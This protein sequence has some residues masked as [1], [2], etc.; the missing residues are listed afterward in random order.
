MKTL[1]VDEFKYVHEAFPVA[2]K[3]ELIK[4]KGVYPYDY[5]DSFTRFD[6]SRLPSQDA[7]ISKLSDSLCSDTEYAHATQVW[8]AFECESMAD[9]HD[10]YLKYDVLLLKIR[11]ACLAQYSLD[12]VHYY[13]APGHA[14]DAALRMTPL[15]LEL[16]IDIDMYHFIEN[17]IRGG[18][19][20]ITMR[21][22]RANAPTLPA[23]DAGRP[24]VSL[25]DLDL[26]N[27]Y[28]WAMSQPL[29]THGFR[30]PQADE[31]ETLADVGD[32]SG[33]AENGY[34]FEVDL[35]YPQHLHDAQNDYLLAPEPL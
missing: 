6:E 19:S 23:Y 30:F 17:S 3:F 34:I 10:M 26:N 15:S 20:M 2:H 13:S 7:F 4:R 1:E 27:L 33:D 22:D 21:Y 35:S 31:I 25:I 8:T 11:A 16:I 32:L 14:W 28:G 29:P 5:N 12:A 24:R 9:N 18:I